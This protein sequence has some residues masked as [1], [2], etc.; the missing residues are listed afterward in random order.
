MIESSCVSP[1][2]FI[3]RSSY[4]EDDVDDNQDVTPTSRQGREKN[5]I[6]SYV[7][8][9]S[10]KLLLLAAAFALIG[11]T[12]LTSQSKHLAERAFSFGKKAPAKS[13]KGLRGSSKTS[14]SSKTSSSRSRKSDTQKDLGLGNSAETTLFDAAAPDTTQ[15]LIQAG[16]TDD[17]VEG[18][19]LEEEMVDMPDISAEEAAATVDGL[20][21]EPSEVAEAET[22]S[23]SEATDEE[24]DAD[25][26]TTSL[27]QAPDDNSD[28]DTVPATTEEDGQ[29]SAQD[30]D[31]RD[32][33]GTST[34]ASNLSEG[35]KT[36]SGASK[37][38]SSTSSRRS[39]KSHSQKDLVSETADAET[40]S[41]T[42]ESDSNP[43]AYAETAS[44][45]EAADANT[46]SQASTS[47]TDKTDAETASYLT[48]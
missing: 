9:N 22:A 31:N 47:T 32:D 11:A 46:G 34:S 7:E 26:E 28:A 40:A 10:K 42:E 27:S 19:F 8:R 23:V 14:K 3:D 21:N 6:I 16:M 29:E 36:S 24:T 15:D 4:S 33:S 38:S 48:T 2:K 35:D 25:A 44:V 37:R 20:L 17:F 5:A 30:A 41:V 12:G 45:S 1:E 18:S 13:A 43:E 39:R